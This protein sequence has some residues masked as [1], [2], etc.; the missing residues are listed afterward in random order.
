MLKREI[1]KLEETVARGSKPEGGALTEEDIASINEEKEEW[2]TVIEENRA[3][4]AEN[5]L[6]IDGQEVSRSYEAYTN[7]LAQEE[8]SS[9]A[10]YAGAVLPFMDTRPA[11]G[12]AAKDLGG[13]LSDI[14]AMFVSFA[15]PIA[16]L[17]IGTAMG[18][19]IS[20]AATAGAAGTPTGPG[21]GLFAVAGFGA[22]LLTS[23]GTQWYMRENESYAE[24]EG[25]YEEKY[26]KIRDD[27]I[28]TN[29]RLPTEQEEAKMS[30]EAEKG[31]DSILAQNKGLYMYD[32][33]EAGLMAMPWGRSLKWL[34]AAQKWKRAVARTGL[35]GG[36]L[37]LN[38]VNESREEGNQFLYK[39]RLYSWKV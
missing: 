4:I 7:Y 8:G 9:V 33:V 11:G 24:A 3:D 2:N 38:S 20:A 18:T 25:A 10:S 15:A 14:T 1:R 23:F 31:F 27:F 29:K 19:A 16:G 28:Y 17:K 21:A 26:N 39:K 34:T 35:A 30:L 13:A 32:L 22:G 12:E 5:Q 36:A 6:E 37:F